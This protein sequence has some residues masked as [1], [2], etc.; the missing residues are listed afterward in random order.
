MWDDIV[1]DHHVFKSFYDIVVFVLAEMT[2]P[3]HSSHSGV[4]GSLKASGERGVGAS[5]HGGGAS[6]GAEGARLRVATHLQ[7]DTCTESESHI[8]SSF[9]LFFHLMFL[10]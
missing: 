7:R 5:L 3:S 6:S 10:C 2:R 9:F 1:L 4:V 8:L